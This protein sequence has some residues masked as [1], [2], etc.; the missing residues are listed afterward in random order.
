MPDPSR[1]P[2]AVKSATK[3]RI[4]TMKIFLLP[5]AVVGQSALD[6]AK[7]KCQHGVSVFAA[8]SRLATELLT[9]PYF[10]DVRKSSS[11]R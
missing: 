1:F 6:S 11:L 8:G 4:F 9:L 2:A 5:V 7:A 3:T 10:R